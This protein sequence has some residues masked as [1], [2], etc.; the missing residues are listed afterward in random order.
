MSTPLPSPP[1]SPLDNKA[2]A[3]TLLEI[4]DLLELKGDNPFKIRAYRNAADIVSHAAE[5]VSSLDEAGLR[6]WN[7]IGKDLAGRIREIAVTGDCEIR[8]ELLT[9][10]PETLLEVLR[11]QGVGPKTVAI[12]YKELRIKSLDD[13]AAAAKAGRIRSIKGMGGKKEQLILQAIEERQR[14]AGRHLLSRATEMAENLVAYLKEHAPAAG[15]ATVGSVRRGAETSGDL[16]IAGSGADATLADAFTRFP[17]VERIL[18]NG[19]TKASVL[20]RG[21]FQADLRIVT[22]DQRG[23][24]L[25]YFTGSKAHNIALRDRAL[26][27]GW[28]LNEYGLFD[29]DDRA[30]GGATEES[31]YKALGLDFIEPELREDRG[32]LDAAADHALP[33]LITRADLKGDLH[34]HTTESDGRESLETMVA[35]ARSRGLEYIAI[36]DHSQS[37][38]MANGLDEARTY[39][40]ADRIRAYSKTQKGITVLAGI[41]CDILADGS[42]DLDDACL[43]SLDIVVASIHSAMT[44]DERDMTARVIKAIEH[45]SV[46]IIGHLTARMLLRREGTRVNVER[47]IDAAKANGVVLEINSQPHRLDLCD[48]HARLARDRGVMLV[49]DSD[50]H[51]IDA[52]DYPRWGVL[53]A[54][55]AWLTKDDV[56][57][58]RPLKKF[59]AG[60]KRN[61]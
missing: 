56:L 25:Q 45:P 36:T 61:R 15:I 38:A 11:L 47:V 31:I 18:A 30:I 16:D 24:A 41:E 58:T 10:F 51:E 60:L 55:R 46:D 44:Q 35:A 49:I 4:A 17:L 23:A 19:G 48:S 42:M 8:R 13:L 21:G 33:Q 3:R 2:V 54:R 14:F 50:G 43:G 22:P 52:L 57:N 29:A 40:H 26:E 28:K 27:R 53:T 6:G 1:L 7:G 20:L 32:E 12:L 59:L 5:A 37:L 34:M 39:A 9:E